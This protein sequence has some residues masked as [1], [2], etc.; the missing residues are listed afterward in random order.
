[1]WQEWVDVEGFDMKSKRSGKFML[2]PVRASSNGV[3]SGTFLLS[4]WLNGRRIRKHFKSRDDALGEKNAL[5]IEAA[6]N[7]GEIRARNSTKAWATR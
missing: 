2:R 7:G 3:T 6:N 1:L 4:G 5:E